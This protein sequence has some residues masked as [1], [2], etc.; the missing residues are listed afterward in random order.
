MLV[1]SRKIHETIWLGDDI[2]LVV[3]SVKGD[4]VRFGIIAPPKVRVD[5]GEI[6]RRFLGRNRS[7]EGAGL[8]ESAEHL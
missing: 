6:R 8:R 3:V 7:N 1:L 4:S 5:R 2:Q